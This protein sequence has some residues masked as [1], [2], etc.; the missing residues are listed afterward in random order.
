MFLAYLFGVTSDG[1]LICCSL[2]T[3][4]Y[5]ALRLEPFTSGEVMC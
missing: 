3:I 4:F 5:S 2:K 1:F